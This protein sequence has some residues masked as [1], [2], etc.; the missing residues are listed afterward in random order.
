MTV[1]VVILISV[2]GVKK[3]IEPTQHEKQVA[4]LKEYENEITSY[5]KNKSGYVKMKNYEVENVAYNWE[6]VSEIQSMSFSSKKLS[7]EVNL[8]D[9]KKII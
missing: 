2:L 8:F 4:F 7:I 6:S 1:L 5:I 9:E 3:M